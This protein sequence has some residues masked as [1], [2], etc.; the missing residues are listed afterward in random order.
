MNIPT[1]IRMP[2]TGRASF[3]ASVIVS[4]MFHFAPENKPENADARNITGIPSD[5]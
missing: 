4:R 3:T 5:T 2:I 1:P